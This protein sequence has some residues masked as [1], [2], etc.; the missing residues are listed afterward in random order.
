MT[1]PLPVAPDWFHDDVLLDSLPGSDK[2]QYARSLHRLR[3]LPVR[4]LRPGHDHSFSQERLH[5]LTDGYLRS[6]A[7]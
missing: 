2:H 3:A 4:L 1:S 5:H 6:A 7:C